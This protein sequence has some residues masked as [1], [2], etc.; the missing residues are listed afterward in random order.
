MKQTTPDL[1]E[2]GH[3]LSSAGLSAH[4][5]RFYLTQTRLFCT[6]AGWQGL[7]QVRQLSE[8]EFNT[9]I[10]NYKSLL[11]SLNLPAASINAKLSALSQLA[12][13]LGHGGLQVQ[14]EKFAVPQV[15]ALSAAQIE[16]LEKYILNNEPLR[17]QAVMLLF[18]R[19]G[20]KMGEVT[21]LE[22]GNL[23]V[24]SHDESVHLRID[25]RRRHGQALMRQVSLDPLL[26]GVL[27]EWLAQL[28]TT[29]SQTPLFPTIGG[30]RL[31]TSAIDMTIRKA[32]WKNGLVLSAQVLRNTYL[33]RLHAAGVP[34][35]HIAHL[36]GLQSIELIDRYGQQ[37]QS[38]G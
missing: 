13:Y 15:S 2:Y 17:N 11:S 27:K 29:D 38:I 22:V 3:W 26:S 18:L 16:A 28:P 24:D 35:H 33:Q 9:V 10:E 37:S 31:S 5:C 8:A 4:T 19:G 7:N 34:A 36:V 21:T 30:K 12:K 20:L 25:K 6:F 23:V 1:S 32:G 14:R